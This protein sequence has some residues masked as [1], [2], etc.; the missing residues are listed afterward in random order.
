MVLQYS[1]IISSSDFIFCETL[2]RRFFLTFIA[3]VPLSSGAQS[4]VKGF[5]YLDSIQRLKIQILVHKCLTR[6]F[7]R[8]P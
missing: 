1:V 7:P 3:S 4:L 6:Y 5:K 2:E 8:D